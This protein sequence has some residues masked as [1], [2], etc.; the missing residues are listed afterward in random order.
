[1]SSG[2]DD[3]AVVLGSG[4]TAVDAVLSLS[5]QPRRAPITLVS[6]NGLLPQAHAATPVPPVDLTSLVSELVAAPG[7]VRARDSVA[8]S[9]RRTVRELGRRAATGG[10]SWTGCARTRPGS[11]GRC[12][13]PSVGGFLPVSVR[14]GRCIGTGWPSTVAEPFRAL[15]ARGDVRLVAGRV[16]SA[17]AEDDVVKLVVRDAAAIGRSSWTQSWV[18]NCTGP[19][20]RTAWSPTR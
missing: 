11:G 8:P 13:R 17:Q 14:S 1:M 20:R 5:Q 10:A 3:P 19:C 6:R 15:L 9:S 16:E 2:P 7:G 4:L 18:I 12:R